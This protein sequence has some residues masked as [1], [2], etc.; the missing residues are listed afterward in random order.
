MID[1]LNVTKFLIILTFCTIFVWD[2]IV[3]FYAKDL[4][5]TLSFSIY[6]ISRQHPIVPFIIG[7]LCGHVFWPLRS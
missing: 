7:V 3:M 2:S 5:A 6:T 4:S 1:F